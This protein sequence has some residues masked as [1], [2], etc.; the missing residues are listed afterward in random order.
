MNARH[1]QLVLLLVGGA[2]VAF[3]YFQR[4][5]AESDTH[6]TTTPTF[7]A[8]ASPVA[9]LARL[10][11]TPLPSPNPVDA[12]AA[13]PTSPATTASTRTQVPVF[14]GDSLDPKF[15][16][17][18]NLSPEDVSKLQEATQKAKERM[19]DLAAHAAQLQMT[20]GGDMIVDIPS[21]AGKG[22]EVY[23]QLLGDFK[24]VLGADKFSDFNA[25]A[26]NSFDHAFDSFGAE[27]S[28]YQIVRQTDRTGNMSV[29]VK[30]TYT[31]PDGSGTAETTVDAAEVDRKYPLLAKIIPADTVPRGSGPR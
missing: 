31:L 8:S 19:Q 24:T 10:P 15:I 2:G 11:E 26:G 17:A 4:A 9:A 20:K 21:L 25:V 7:K 29:Q 30:K 16:A 1:V 22:G 14:D 28:H 3:W 12:A 5:A 27:Q 23:E 18:F 13:A 6:A